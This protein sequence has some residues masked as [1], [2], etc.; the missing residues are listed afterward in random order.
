MTIEN[1]M[2]LWVKRGKVKP[3][4]RGNT[5]P[6]AE[7]DRL[8]LLL[9]QVG[10][11]LQTEL[12]PNAS[13]YMVALCPKAECRGILGQMLGTANQICYN[14][15]A[16]YRLAKVEDE[17]KGAEPV[18]VYNYGFPMPPAQCGT[19]EDSEKCRNARVVI[20][21]FGR[22]SMTRLRSFTRILLPNRAEITVTGKTKYAIIDFNLKDSRACACN[23]KF[24]DTLFRA[25]KQVAN[26]KSTFSMGCTAGNIKIPRRN[27]PYLIRVLYLLLE[28]IDK[29]AP[30][31]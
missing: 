12:F 16:E 24:R 11:N 25:Y 22:H 3:L 14:C 8:E 27:G 28:T 7:Y 30:A 15:G 31:K 20:E 18:C 4:E 19:C 1:K 9:E 2:N 29:K 10:I 23:N 26:D 5:M 17:E 21:S 6:K 13:F